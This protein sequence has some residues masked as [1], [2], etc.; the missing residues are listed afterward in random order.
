METLSWSCARVLFHNPDNGFCIMRLTRNRRYGDEVTVIGTLITRPEPGAELACE[1][2]YVFNAKYKEQQFKAS[3]LERKLPST[4]QGIQGYLTSIPGIG[5]HFARLLVDH[6]GDDTLKVIDQEPDR[7]DDVKGIGKV[8]REALVSACRKHHSVQDIMVFLQTYGINPAN[9]ARIHKEFGDR[10]REVIQGDPYLMMTIDRIGFKIADAVAIKMGMAHDSPS[11]LQAGIKYVLDLYAGNGNTAAPFDNLVAKA[12]HMLSVNTGAVK[13]ELES[14]V[15]AGALKK[16]DIDGHTC[17]M[18]PHLYYTELGIARQ[19]RRLDDARPSFGGQPVLAVNTGLTPMQL[20]G[21]Q[22][23]FNHTLSILTGGPGT[24]KT[25]T[26]KSVVETAEGM[27]INPVLC[28]PTGKAARRMTE[29]TGREARTLHSLLEYDG[30]RFGRDA[31]RPLEGRFFIID[32]SSMIDAA[33]LHG[34]LKSVKDGARILFCGDVDQL[35]SVGPGNVLHDM[36]DSR[37]IA[38]SRLTEVHRQAQGSHI[39]Q[40]A[41]AINQGVMPQTDLPADSDFLFIETGD[42]AVTV[43]EVVRLAARDIFVDYGIRH[44]DI[45][46]LSPMKKGDAGVDHLNQVLQSVIN[47]PN[48]QPAVNVFG[49]EYRVNDRIMQMRNNSELGINN[50]EVGTILAIDKVEGKVLVSVDFNGRPVM[51]ERTDMEDVKLA[52][53]ATI[54]KSQG[55]EF[56]AVLVVASTNH[57]NMLSRKLYYTAVTRGKQQVFVV[58]SKKALE[59]AV[60]NHRDTRRITGLKGWIEEEFNPGQAFVSGANRPRVRGSKVETTEFTRTARKAPSFRWG[61]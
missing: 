61:I 21:V 8:R 49:V 9:A 5:G 25:T 38:V 15:I 47:P 33:L 16:R 4:A 52:Y 1:G 31:A 14:M 46:V 53:C 36:I 3:R 43:E 29:A 28:A 40:A 7:L 10:A 18:P 34:F 23:T 19:L 55:S 35:E 60:S 13:D 45:Q 12:A 30:K 39:V 42:D 57:W 58:G 27:G 22:Q 26:V 56:G 59:L 44:Q 32:E 48:E 54:H 17:I 11:R 51:L 2:S 6:F 50:G 37:A 24:G 41:H 20:A